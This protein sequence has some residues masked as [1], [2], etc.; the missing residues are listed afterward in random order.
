MRGAGGVIAGVCGAVQASAM[1]SAEAAGGT[2]SC[3]VIRVCVEKG[4]C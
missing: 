3:F 4:A 1:G 2:G